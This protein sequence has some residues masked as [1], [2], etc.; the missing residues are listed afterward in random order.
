MM[1]MEIQRLRK[2]GFTLVAAMLGVAAIEVP[3]AICRK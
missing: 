2:A 3:M 1:P